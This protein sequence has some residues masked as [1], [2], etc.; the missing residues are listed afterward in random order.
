[1]QFHLEMTEHMVYDWLERY[2]DCMPDPS[3]TVQSAEQI[4]NRLDERL[5]NLHKTADKIYDWWLCN[6][7]IKYT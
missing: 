5:K 4:I 1:M 3:T 6:T 7:G 2:K